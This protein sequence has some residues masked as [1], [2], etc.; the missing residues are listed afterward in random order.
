MKILYHHRVAAQD[1]QSIHIQA[2]VAA[3]KRQGHEVIFIGPSMRPSELG[4]ENKLL[5]LVRTLFPQF[6]QEFLEFLYGIR[7]YFKLKTAVK[8][9]KPDF[10]YERY[11]LFLA[12]GY[13]LKKKIDIPYIVEVNAPLIQERSEFGNLKLKALAS[14]YERK[15]FEAADLVLPVTQVLADII[16]PQGASPTKTLVLHNGI[17]PEQYV[18]LD[19]SDF[20]EQYGLANKTVLGF[21][22]FI[23]EWHQLDKII[24]MM[25]ADKNL[26]DL[27]LL[28]VGN[29][30]AVEECE[31][32]AAS[33]GIAD[34][35]HFTG[36]KGREAIPALLAVMDI[37]LQPAVTAYASPLKMFEYMAAKTAIVAP[38]QANIR[39]ILK[40][41]ETA[42]LF[43]PTEPDSARAAI[44]RLAK[45]KDLRTQL[46]DA[47]NQSIAERRFTW[48]DNAKRIVDKVKALKPQ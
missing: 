31:E 42:L 9:H 13:W 41:E 33:L 8:L 17:V 36:F 48:D 24:E 12:A 32:I 11:N 40:N 38:D 43:D 25:A 3:F 34:R 23:R 1:G 26:R 22:G 19:G 16:E 46:G 15:T 2:L 18:N 37:T 27:H 6:L 10:I 5:K 14:R 47:A 30:P 4:D 20:I 21:I 45:D 35:V 7:A 29:G 28:A 44:T 39:E